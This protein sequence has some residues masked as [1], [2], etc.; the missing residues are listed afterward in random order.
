M[1]FLPHLIGCAGSDN[2]RRCEK[3]EKKTQVPLRHHSLRIIITTRQSKIEHHCQ[4][5]YNYFK[6]ELRM[7]SRSLSGCQSV[8][9][10]TTSL[11]ISVCLSLS[12]CLQLWV[13]GEKVTHRAGQLKTQTYWPKNAKIRGRERFLGIGR[14]T[15]YRAKLVCRSNILFSSSR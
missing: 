11:P 6:Q 3:K 12:V 14:P 13:S 4:F 8:N 1:S 15:Y 5:I 7:L 9:G 10:V 2:Q